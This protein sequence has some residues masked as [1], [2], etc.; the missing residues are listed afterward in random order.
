MGNHFDLS[1]SA[2]IDSTTDFVWSVDLQSRLTAFNSALDLYYKNN[3]GTRASIGKLP[4]ELLPPERAGRWPILYKRA[5]TEGTFQIESTNFDGRT[6]Q[7][8]FNR[9]ATNGEVVGVSVFG[10]DITDLK[11]AQAALAEAELEY[12][13]IFD[14][15]LE[16][17]FRTNAN[18]QLLTANTTCAMILGYG[19]SQ[20]LLSGVCDVGADVWIDPS[21]RRRYLDRIEQV[22][23]RELIGYECQFKRKDG[24][25]IWVSLSS[26]RISE[27]GTSG[28]F[29]QG[30]IVDITRRKQSEETMRDS[31]EFLEQAQRNGVLGWYVLDI[32]TGRWSSSTTLDHLFG[33]DDSYE[34][35]VEGWLNLVHPHDRVM[36][37]EHASEAIHGDVKAFDKEYRIVRHSDKAGLWVHGLG[38]VQFDER[39]S[40]VAMRGIIRDI[41]DRKES[42]RRICESEERYRATFEQAPVGILHTSLDG[43]ILRCNLTFAKIIGYPLEEVRGLTFQEITIPEDLDKSTEALKS[44]INGG[45]SVVTWEKRYCRKD[46]TLTW[47]KLTVSIQHGLD[48]RPLHFITLVEDINERKMTEELLA[49]SQETLRASET[50]YRTVFQTSLDCIAI[51]RVSDGVYVEVNRAFLQL[52]KY[53]LDDVIGKSSLE[54]DIWADPSD[55]RKMIDELHLKNICNSFKARFRKKDGSFLWGLISASLIDLE[56]VPCMLSVTRDVSA[57]EAAEHE[58]RNLAFLDTLTGLANRRFLL[59]R[60]R[61]PRVSN[62]RGC[63][64]ALLFIDLDNFKILND[65]LGHHA[66]DLLLRQAAMRLSE[67]VRKDDTV[68]RLGGDEFVVLLEGLSEIH[69][70]AVGEVRVIADEV[71]QTLRVPYRIS[72]QNYFSTA[73]IGICVFR[74]GGFDSIDIMQQADIAM[75]Q[76]K[77]AG[78]DT[79]CFFT[80]ALKTAVNARA[81]LEEELRHAVG[82]D[83]FVLHF[84]PQVDSTGLVAAEAL[85]RWMH[86]RRGLL[87]PGEFISVAEDTGLILPIGEWVI[88]SACNQIAEWAKCV[89]TAH[90]TLA[91]NISARQFRHPDF[92]TQVLAALERTGADPTKLKLE[93]TESI[94]VHDFEDVISKMRILESYGLRFSLDDF[95]TGYSSLAYLRRLP[96]SELKVDQVF[97]R[98]LD[99]E[100]NVAIIQTIISLGSAMGVPVIAEGVETE[101]QRDLLISIGCHS[102]QGFLF[103]PPL[104][105]LEFERLAPHIALTSPR[106]G[107]RA[108]ENELVLVR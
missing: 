70:E 61:Q 77:A 81:T 56:G 46:R 80:P 74:E 51:N 68:A 87:S 28:P 108:V 92:V 62:T 11:T 9:I 8:T 55:R 60:L 14:R 22:G 45:P 48:G 7:L 35:T 1:L 49:R 2:L 101:A 16:G 53:R 36:M 100:V 41:T 85:I 57:A 27:P 82:A 37:T 29:Y 40:P 104:P 96:L 21:E 72:E 43:E 64:R 94:L 89:A 17:M 78:R 6:L 19:S 20:E 75:Y 42:E 4:E 44:M 103:S 65:T 32:S 79:V 13:S 97:V 34:R 88:R 90:I 26:R 25:S 83:Q 98:D 66:G 105:L 31:A 3:F 10:R 39:G 69:D 93:L 76:A 38:K 50:R 73:S 12:H 52:M 58:I 71:L 99:M 15:A 86:P 95:G 91:V 107:Q 23:S 30:F 84:Q 47:A 63:S 59:E 33:I 5:L 54:L 106:N 102:F 18:G 24:A 67:S